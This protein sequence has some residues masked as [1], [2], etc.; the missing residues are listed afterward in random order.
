M[1]K[2]EIL[3]KV[4]SIFDDIFDEPQITQQTK[5]DDI[6]DWDSLSQ[7]SLVCA[8]EEDFGVKFSLE[9]LQQLNSVENII[10]ILQSK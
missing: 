3:T 2:D 6:Q 10:K 5:Q 7:I 9:E 1:K 8:L 4:Q